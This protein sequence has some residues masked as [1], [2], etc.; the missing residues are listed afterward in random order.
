MPQTSEEPQVFGRGDYRVA[1]H[2]LREAGL[3]PG[4]MAYVMGR[5]ADLN[6]KHRLIFLPVFATGDGACYDGKGN[7]AVVLDAQDL[8]NLNPDSKLK[9]SA[10]PLAPERL[11]ELRRGDKVLYILKKEVKIINR[12][13]YVKEKGSGRYV[14]ASDSVEKF[15]NFV[16][17]GKVNVDD[18][19]RMVGEES[20]SDNIMEISFDTDSYNSPIMRAWIVGAVGGNW[21]SD[22][23]GDLSL[24]YDARL[25]AANS[26]SA[27][28]APQI[29]HEA[30][31]TIKAHTPQ[32]VEKAKE[33]TAKLRKASD[34]GVV[35][36]EIV[37]SLEDLLRKL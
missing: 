31:E 17:R 13:G 33:S 4:S 25:A 9:S 22:A 30:T 29:S 37:Q 1:M 7:A 12:S 16:A 5:R 21:R 26:E 6:N 8:W 10:L 23:A 15:W 20:R 27:G 36:L 32:D 2:D 34:L 28:G 19:A 35:Q 24:D 11:E 14:P 3:V 18:Y